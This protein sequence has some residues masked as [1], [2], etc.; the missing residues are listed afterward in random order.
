MKKA[1]VLTTAL[2][3]CATL[4]SL[5]IAR[6]TLGKAPIAATAATVSISNFQ[7]APKTV[8]VKA[9]GE[10]TWEV[11]QGTH[12][13]TSD[14]GTFESQTLSTGNKF[15]YKFTKPGTY[16]YYCSFHGSKGGHDM[17][18]VVRVTR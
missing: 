12:T 4:V 8:T 1:I 5:S 14:D 3:I 2:V 16:R 11:K 7:F 17:S 18:G 6:L 15:S 10:V 13:V 9:G